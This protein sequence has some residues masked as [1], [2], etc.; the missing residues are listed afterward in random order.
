MGENDDAC[1]QAYTT[2][3]QDWRKVKYASGGAAN[4]TYTHCDRGNFS[5]EWYRFKEPA[6]SKLPIAAPGFQN[7]QQCE[8]CQTQAPAWVKEKRYPVLGEGV[9]VIN[10]C[11]SYAT[12]ECGWEVQGKTVACQDQAGS[13]FYLYCL[14]PTKG[15]NIAY[16]A[17]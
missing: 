12:T 13:L 4:C 11:F 3:N 10:I 17:L 6:G 16:C 9:I 2:L 1:N 7:G 8:V 5:A 14:P 15:C